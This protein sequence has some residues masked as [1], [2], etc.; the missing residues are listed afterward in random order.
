[1][2]ID[3]IVATSGLYDTA[4]KA[5][6]PRAAVCGERFHPDDM[7]EAGSYLA[8]RNFGSA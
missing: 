4:G 1:M 8:I 6:F 2:C 3:R 5:G 7:I